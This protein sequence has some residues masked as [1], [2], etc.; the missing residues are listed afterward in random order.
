MLR[1]QLVVCAAFGDLA[2]GEDEN[3]VAVLDRR[4]SVRHKD[5]CAAAPDAREAMQDLR[6]C[7]R[8]NG[9]EGVVQDQDPRLL[10]DRSGQRGTLLLTSGKSDAAL[11]DDRVVLLEEMSSH[12][13]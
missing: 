3:L 5:R 6:L 12:R 11:A 1:D 4:D 10:G 7:V 2:V 13:R 8:V 9:G